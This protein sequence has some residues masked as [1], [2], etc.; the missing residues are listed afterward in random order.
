LT[1]QVDDDL[2]QHVPE[3]AQD[4][5]FGYVAQLPNA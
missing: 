3:E 2:L 4:A 1:A 5:V